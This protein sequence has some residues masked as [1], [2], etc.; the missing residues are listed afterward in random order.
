MKLIK[1]FYILSLLTLVFFPVLL[2]ADKIKI[3][4]DSMRILRRG[5]IIEFTGN[6]KVTSP[7]MTATAERATMAQ[8]GEVVTAEGNVELY[9]SSG[10]WDFSGW[11]EKLVFDRGQGYMNIQQDVKVIYQPG[12]TATTT[13]VFADNAEV[14]FSDGRQEGRFE[15]NVIA[16]RGNVKVTAGLAHYDREREVFTFTDDPVAYSDMEQA[17]TKYKGERIVFSLVVEE[18]SMRGNAV[19][20][21]KIKDVPG[22]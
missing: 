15:G 3:D 19:T 21:I 2:R 16:V 6:V 10:A 17:Y 14:N 7:E 1:K 20:R 11:G 22:M 18:V 4:S 5:E 9:Y 8:G 12:I 13:V